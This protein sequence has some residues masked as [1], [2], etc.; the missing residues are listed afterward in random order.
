MYVPVLCRRCP[1]LPVPLYAE[2]AGRMGT[3]K[4]PGRTAMQK[5]ERYSIALLD[6]YLPSPGPGELL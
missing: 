2:T 1:W 6:G 5:E 4:A 3:A